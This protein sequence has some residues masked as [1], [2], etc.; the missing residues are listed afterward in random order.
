M[1]LTS[2]FFGPHESAQ[3][4]T[5]DLRTDDG[6]I[7]PIGGQELLGILDSVDSRGLDV[8]LHEAGC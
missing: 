1:W 7:Q 2:G 8:N 4:L 6:G 5:V 3:E